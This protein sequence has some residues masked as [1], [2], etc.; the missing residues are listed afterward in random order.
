MAIYLGISIQPYNDIEIGAD[1]N[2]VMVEDAAA[3]GQHARQRLSFFLGEWF[4]DTTIGV[5]WF[6]KVFGLQATDSERAIAEAIVKACVLDTPG[7]TALSEISTK[8]DRTTR[9]FVVERCI[10]ET[11]FDETTTV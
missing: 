3:V 7:V 11:E 8:R 2:L 9:G 10:V 4:L 1:G 6:G 5:D